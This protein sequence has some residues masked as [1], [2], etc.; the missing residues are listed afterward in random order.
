MSGVSPSMASVDLNAI[1]IA[2]AN[3]MKNSIA[4]HVQLGHDSFG[5]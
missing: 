3:V 4:Y 2:M 5:M 1:T